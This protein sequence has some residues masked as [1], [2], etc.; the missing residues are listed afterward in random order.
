MTKEVIKY[1]MD[2]E[3]EKSSKGSGRRLWIKTRLISRV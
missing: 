2:P 3:T 1:M